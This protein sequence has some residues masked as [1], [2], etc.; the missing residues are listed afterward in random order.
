M[1]HI[2]SKPQ[3]DLT[4]ILLHYPNPVLFAGALSSYLQGHCGEPGK[5]IKT[6]PL[7]ARISAQGAGL[8]ALAHAASWEEEK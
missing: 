6:E 1:M 3:T 4:D 2:S 7:L 8:V 5:A